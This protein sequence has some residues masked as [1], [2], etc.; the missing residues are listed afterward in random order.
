MDQAR[1]D[2]L[3]KT[4]V[5]KALIPLSIPAIIAMIVTALYNLTDTIF[6]GQ[7]SGEIAIGALSIA[8]PVQMIV[9]A[10][11]LMIGIGSAS[12]FS[13]AYGRSDAETMRRA[14]NTAIFMGIVFSVIIAGLGLLFLDE[15]LV[16]FGATDA[17]IGFAKDYLFYI[18]IGLIPF[19][20]SV[21]FNNLARAEGRAKIAMISMIIGAGVNIILDP[22][23]IFDW[24]L[25]LGI[26]GAAIAT[27]IAK[28]ASFIYVFLASISSQ[29]KLKINL[30]KLYEIDFGMMGEISIIGFSSFIRNALG[31]FLVILINNLI[32][33]YSPSP[34]IYISIFGVVNRLLMFLLMPGFGLVQ[35]LQPL[36]GYNFGAKFYQRLYDVIG[37]TMKLLIFYFIGALVITLVFADQLFTLFTS[38]TDS[39]LLTQG[40][41]ALRVVAIGFT[42]IGFQIILSSV[43][44][45]MGYPV[46]AFVVALS[47]QFIL[48]VPIV[49]LFTY[50]F[51]IPGIWWTFVA[52][53]LIAGLVSFFVYLYEMRVL[54]SKIPLTVSAQEVS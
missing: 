16:F 25:G 8:N 30:A 31:A 51:G 7:G 19:S 26:K 37:Y 3:G 20:L 12:I 9:M 41:N 48:F 17:N 10:F 15:L 5:K 28:F 6:V 54:K 33:F 21:I 42:V 46:R 52:A 27:V 29:S 23:F 22:I 43:Y 50:W 53:D 14:V 38:E 24:G 1:S 36:V 18:L 47:R 45:A 35:G 11:G 40:P 4:D 32:N 39:I 34:E 2:L 13:R 49:L 44:Q